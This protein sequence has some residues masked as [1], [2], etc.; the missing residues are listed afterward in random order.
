MVMDLHNTEVRQGRHV[1]LGVPNMEAYETE[2]SAHGRRYRIIL[3]ERDKGRSEDKSTAVFNDML[4]LE[5]PRRPA[6]T[7]AVCVARRR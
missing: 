1:L 6:V 4:D 5:W 2:E 3:E 7:R